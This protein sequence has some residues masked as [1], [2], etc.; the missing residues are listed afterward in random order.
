MTT[1][2]DWTKDQLKPLSMFDTAKWWADGIKT[3]GA[4]NG[5]GFLT[6]GT[7][8]ATFHDHHRAFIEVKVAGFAFFV[9]IIAFALALLFLY[10]AVDAQDEVAKAYLRNDV[11]A[12]SRNS[13]RSGSSWERANMF[14]ALSMATFFVGCFVGLIAFLSF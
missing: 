7:A 5:A 3:M 4:G 14:V 10:F 2:E 1:L 6:A 12:G 13:A 11:D 9:G 8:L